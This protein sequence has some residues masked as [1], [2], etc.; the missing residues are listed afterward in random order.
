[1]IPVVR[2][3]VYVMPLVAYLAGKFE[4]AL[5]AAGEAQPAGSSQQQAKDR[6]KAIQ[7]SMTQDFGMEVRWP[8]EGGVVFT[9]TTERGMLH[10][11]RALAAYTFCCVLFKF[12]RP[13]PGRVEHAQNL[14]LFAFYSVWHDIGQSWNNQLQC[15]SHAP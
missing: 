14:D 2:L 12:F 10:A 3:N 7:D 9:E 11:L 15:P 4:P 5:L 6:V 8:D 13:L 1:M